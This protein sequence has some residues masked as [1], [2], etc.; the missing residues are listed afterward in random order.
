MQDRS[1]IRQRR[2]A[3]TYKLL[4]ECHHEPDGELLG[5]L[6]QT[7]SETI[8]VAVD[9]LRAATTDLETMRVDYAKLFVGPFEVLAPPYGSSY[10]DDADRVVTDSTADVREQYREEGLD[11]GMD[12]PADHVAAELEFACI[13]ALSEAEAI[14]TGDYE[15]A[16]TYARRRYEFLSEHLGRWVSELADNIRNQAE[17]EFYR[18]LADETQSFVESD[19]TQLAGKVEQLDDAET[20]VE[21]ALT[22]GDRS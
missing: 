20:D 8:G 11:I 14:E 1:L 13:L 3:N 7:S 6:E 10:L 22:G 15:T 4:T 21:E 2:R 16:A 17:T 18:R 19:G 5:L 12:E 9:E